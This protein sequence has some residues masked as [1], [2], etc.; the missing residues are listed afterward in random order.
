MS[1][2]PFF[3][4]IKLRLKVAKGP[5]QYPVARK[6][7]N[8]ANPDFRIPDLQ[9]FPCYHITSEPCSF[10][11]GILGINVLL[12]AELWTCLT[13]NRVGCLAELA[14][15]LV[16][17]RLDLSPSSA[18]PYTDGVILLHLFKLF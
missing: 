7:E 4:M 11:Q 2:D 14:Q 15:G 8:N 6:R 13:Q 5:A 18:L 9:L 17:E 1:L 12:Q 10:R 3:H 16:P